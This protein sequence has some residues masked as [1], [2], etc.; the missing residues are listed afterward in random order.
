MTLAPERLQATQADIDA[1]TAAVTDYLEGWVTGDAKR[2]ARAYH[3]ECVKR[4]MAVDEETGVYVLR[5]ISPQT[6]VDYAATGSSVV[7]DCEF[8]IVIDA[9]SEDMASVRCYSCNWVD[10][11][12]LVKAREEWRLF[13][14][15]WHSQ[16]E[17]EA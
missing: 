14:V 8:E 10:F 6:M 16:P 12:H 5:T 4:R 13:H 15:V 2:H 3:P 9:I 17:A 11:I 7:E 1:V